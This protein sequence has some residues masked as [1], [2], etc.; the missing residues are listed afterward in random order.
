MISTKFCTDSIS[1]G[2]FFSPQFVVNSEKAW[3]A[4]SRIIWGVLF[5][6]ALKFDL[7]I[8]SA[9]QSR[10]LAN[11]EIY[12]QLLKFLTIWDQLKPIE[13]PYLERIIMFLWSSR[14]VFF[15]H[16]QVFIPLPTLRI[17]LKM[18]VSERLNNESCAGLAM[19]WVQICPEEG[20]GLVGCFGKKGTNGLDAASRQA[21]WG[22]GSQ[23]MRRKRSS[24]PIQ[25]SNPIVQSN[26]QIQLSNPNVQSDPMRRRTNPIQFNDKTSLPSSKTQKRRI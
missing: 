5:V 23:K 14:L 9:K 21:G 3:V 25:S 22:R 7:L 26:C 2:C 1:R 6:S 11:L 10:L 15:T 18:E 24:R 13:T 19:W 8:N 17:L 12:P 16:P 4:C 20:R